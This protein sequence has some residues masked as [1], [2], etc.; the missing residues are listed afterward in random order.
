[1]Y[2]FIFATILC[3]RKQ[4]KHLYENLYS[5]LKC[6]FLFE[7]STHNKSNFSQ[8]FLGTTILQTM[9]FFLNLKM[10]ADSLID[11]LELKITLF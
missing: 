4:D 7:I 6:P 11:L 10:D 8:Y 1:M 2:I 9:W 5:E 3:Q